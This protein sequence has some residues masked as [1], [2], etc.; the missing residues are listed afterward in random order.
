M[1]LIGLYLLAIVSAN[2][3]IA[4]FGAQIAILNAFLFIGLDLTARDSLHEQWQSKHLWR[5]MALLIGAGSV[6]SAFLN[7]NALPIAVASFV[8]FAGAGVAD[9]LVYSLLG[10][11]SRLVRMN[12]SNLVSAAVDSLVF[13]AL[14]F[15]F[16]LLWGIVIGQF[17]AKVVGGAVWSMVL[18]RRH[19]RVVLGLLR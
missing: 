19:R 7:W 2:L 5:N 9:T 14:A 15:G 8:A 3:L 12:G 1:I 6:L 10:E 4:Q 11:R 17:A 16:P 18:T 13:P